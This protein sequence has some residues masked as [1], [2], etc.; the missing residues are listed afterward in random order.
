MDK[1]TTHKIADGREILFVEVPSMAFGFD[2]QNYTTEVELIYMLDL[3]QIDHG[4]KEL[5]SDET[6][7]TV[8]LPRAGNWS[9]IGVSDQMSEEE[10][11]GVVESLPDPFSS[12]GHRNFKDY[13][14]TYFV[15]SDRYILLRA[16]ES[17]TFLLRSLGLDTTK[18][19][20]LIEKMKS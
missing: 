5:E 19:Y 12:S 15:T 14:K 1:L 9:I 10:C 2:I 11:A 4:N 17:F 13:T 3:E 18:R 6:L 16:K 8:K 7:V 20:V